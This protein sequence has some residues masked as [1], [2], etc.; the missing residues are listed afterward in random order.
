VHPRVLIRPIT[1]ADAA[2]LSEAHSRLSPETVR[3]RYLA[4]KPRL[5]DRELRYL[6]E[7]DGIDH[8]AFVALDPE[9]ERRIVAVARFVR[10]A[11]EP[12]SAEAA[13]VVADELQ[14]QGLGRRMGTVLADSAR[15]HGID[16]FTATLLT[17]N[18]AAHRLFV[19]ISQRLT[20]T[21]AGSVEELVAELPDAA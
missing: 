6:T 7:V 12:R 5:S 10:A 19:A 16:R 21:R 17:D 18:E 14:G 13:I 8:V 3:R 11:D 4:A 15:E 9:D 20:H 1:P 2:A